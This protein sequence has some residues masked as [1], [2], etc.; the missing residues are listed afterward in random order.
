[1][2]IYTR[3]RLYTGIVAMTGFAF[4][5]RGIYDFL[6]LSDWAPHGFSSRGAMANVAFWLTFSGVIFTG[7]FIWYFRVQRRQADDPESF[8]LLKQKENHF[9]LGISAGVI[10]CL[11]SALLL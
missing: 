11:I 7:Y 5:A 10:V 1:M 3:F 2:N 8:Y 4:I 9:L 6:N